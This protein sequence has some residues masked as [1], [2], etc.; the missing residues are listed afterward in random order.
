M[1]GFERRNVKF[2]VENFHEAVPRPKCFDENILSRGRIPRHKIN[3][4]SSKE[5]GDFILC[6]NYTLCAN[7]WTIWKQTKVISVNHSTV[8]N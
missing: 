4:P 2:S 1:C 8:E 5:P 7:L 6:C 3:E